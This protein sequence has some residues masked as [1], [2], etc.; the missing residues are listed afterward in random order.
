[1]MLSLPRTRVGLA[2]S[3]VGLVL[4][5]TPAIAKQSEPVSRDLRL[6]DYYDF[7]GLSELAVAPE[8]G[9]VVFVRSDI[10]A[11]ADQRRS[12]I[13]TMSAD[14]ADLH[15]LVAEGSAPPVLARR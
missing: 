12:S 11:D 5:A 10:D 1:M 2:T 13:W 15:K 7:V 8:G 14:G 3:V 6:A 9:T 4:A